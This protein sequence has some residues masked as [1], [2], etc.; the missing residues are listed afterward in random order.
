MK[1]IT[2]FVLIAAPFFASAQMD[3]Q[4]LF[5][6]RKTEKYRKM[7]TTGIGFTAVGGLLAIVGIVKMSGATYTT[8]PYTGQQTSNDPEA[9]LGAKLF[10]LS[11]P[12][13]GVG[14]PFTIIGSIN[15]HRYNKRLEN[16]TLN[17]NLS[18]SN[19]GIGLTYKF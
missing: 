15:H 12:C 5:Y 19:Q 13:L 18:P 14:I 11:L 1:T 2:L 8:N 9:I 16:M 3:E 6:L 17:L 10:L 4:K 7:K